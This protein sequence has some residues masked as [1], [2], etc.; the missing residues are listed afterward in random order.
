MPQPGWTVSPRYAS[1]WQRFFAYIIDLLIV[2]SIGL[3]LRLIFLGTRGALGEVYVSL[4]IA[5]VVHAVY[6]IWLW[7]SGQT[8]GMRALNLRMVRAL[9]GGPMDVGR[10]TLR[11]VPFGLALVV[12]FIGVL[13]WLVMAITTAT[14]ARRQGVQDKL[15][16]TLVLAV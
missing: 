3:V 16:G 5:L 13:I 11:F 1:F 14:D 7:G 4:L 12:A 6:F 8:V 15:A 2:G 9:D 10:A